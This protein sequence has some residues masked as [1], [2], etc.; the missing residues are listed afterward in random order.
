MDLNRIYSSPTLTDS[1]KLELKN[2]L[3]SSLPE[4]VRSSNFAN[5]APYIE[6]AQQDSW[7]NARLAQFRT[8]NSNK[9]EFEALFLLNNSNIS[10]FIAHVQQ[11]VTEAQDPFEAISEALNVQNI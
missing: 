9:S 5:P 2:Q 3:I 1:E 11:I 6:V 4:R 8:Y 7:N 10:A